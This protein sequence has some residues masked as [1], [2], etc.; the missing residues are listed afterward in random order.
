MKEAFTLGDVAKPPECDAI[1]CTG[2][3]AGYT[4]LN[5]E[6]TTSF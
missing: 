2:S 4:A 6:K 1:I 5:H 3:Q